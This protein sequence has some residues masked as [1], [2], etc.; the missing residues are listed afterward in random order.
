MI[1]IYKLTLEVSMSNLKI[2][3]FIDHL[4]H[5]FL[6]HFNANR[7]T[8]TQQQLSVVLMVRFMKKFLTLM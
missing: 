4:I 2:S 6:F 7:F 1:T 8:A 5:G 3:K